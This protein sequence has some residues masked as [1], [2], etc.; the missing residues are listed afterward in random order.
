M[1]DNLIFPAVYSP[2]QDLIASS[3][4]YLVGGAVRDIL[5]NRAIHDL[6]FAL[7]KGSIPLARKVAD[8]LGGDFYLLDRE[9]QA[10]RVII[11]DEV[12][13]RM[14]VDFTLFQGLDIMEDLKARDFTITSMAQRLS[15]DQEIIDPCGGGRDIRDRVIRSTTPRALLHDPLRCLRAVRLAAQLDFRILPETK[16]QIREAYPG[17]AEVSGE[18]IRDEIFR[19]L[20]G[21]HQAAAFY[22]LDQL[23]IYSGLFQGSFTPELG[24]TLRALDSFWTL[25]LSEHNQDSAANWYLGLFAHRLGRYRDAVQN[26]LREELVPG[27][28]VYQLSY[29]APLYGFTCQEEPEFQ[30]PRDLALSNPEQDR[31]RKACLAARQFTQLCQCGAVV[32]PLTA[33]R[34]FRDVGK[35]GVE[36]IFISLAHFLGNASGEDR[37][38][39]TQRLDTARALQEGWWEKHDQWVEPP[40]LLDGNDLQREL[41]LEPGPLLGKLLEQLREAQVSRGIQSTEQALDFLQG[42]SRNG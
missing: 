7:P 10:A 42:L 1:N 32:A 40:V 37:A 30:Q 16:S 23:G 12:R 21:P 38:L 25:M 24:R 34:Y 20:D 27:R 29:L 3:G 35:A 28:S 33:Y 5:L 36:G 19:I 26:L 4:A 39:W 11:Q 14:M 6:D 13:G 2:I 15:G 41:N 22:S 8:R 17:L 18:R 31:I 9:R